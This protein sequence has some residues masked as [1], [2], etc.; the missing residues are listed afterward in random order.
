MNNNSTFA[1][2]HTESGPVKPAKAVPIQTM[3]N[4][5]ASIQGKH[6]RGE[7]GTNWGD[8]AK[9][10]NK[11]CNPH[12]YT[13]IQTILNKALTEAA[14]KS[15]GQSLFR[16][17]LGN[18]VCDSAHAKFKINRRHHSVV[19]D[20]L[21]P[22]DDGEITI[23]YNVDD[24]VA[25][26][27]ELSLDSEHY[28][29]G[30]GDTIIK[31]CDDAINEAEEMT[32]EDDIY[33]TENGYQPIMSADMR[34]L[35]KIANSIMESD[36]GGGDA[37]GFGEAD[38]AA[39]PAGGDMG[40]GAPMGGDAG[41]AGGG[42]SN[43]GGDVDGPDREINFADSIKGELSTVTPID[44]SQR[45]TFQKLCSIIADKMANELKKK[46]TGAQLTGQQILNG[47]M[48]INKGFDADEKISM[49]QDKYDLFEGMVYKKELSA[50]LN[51]LD[52]NDVDDAM[53]FESWLY[54][55]PTMQKLAV[56]K[57]K[58]QWIAQKSDTQDSLKL[59][60][61]G[62]EVAGGNA[63]GGN[64]AG[65]GMGAGIGGG[66]GGDSAGVGGGFGGGFG[67]DM[68]TG[69]GGNMG[70]GMDTGMGGDLGGGYGG[71]GAGMG[72]D[73]GAGMGGMD[74]GMGGAGPDIKS[75]GKVD[76]ISQDTNEELPNLGGDATVP[77]D[78][79]VP[80]A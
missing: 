41:A 14:A 38:F 7:K 53:T 74:A 25:K 46:G 23:R 47:T 18:V 8:L 22:N 42:A 63:A 43:L 70:G 75:I 60:P 37:S 32:E 48:G 28:I 15:V 80:T 54:S 52:N 2:V 13:T 27:F 17:D 16:L 40:G 4:I 64:A 31:C 62:S 58:T 20:M 33:S 3:K 5:I 67:G 68:G 55:N 59:P 10:V 19:V 71:M 79:N 73:L 35:L 39:A 36:M 50:L 76:E 29:N 34:G 24:T 44:K 49:F 69:I 45:G 61:D 11:D 72:G 1:Y 57:G 6:A 56:R 30:F 12:R 78:N 9:K 66:F 51:Y 21:Y 26:Q 77:E 65:A